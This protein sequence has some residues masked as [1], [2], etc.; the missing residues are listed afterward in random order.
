MNS[1][2]KVWS[3]NDNV[4]YRISDLNS[5]P[6][7]CYLDLLFVLYV[8]YMLYVLMVSSAMIIVSRHHG[9][10]CYIVIY[11]SVI[12]SDSNTSLNFRNYLPTMFKSNK[13]FSSIGMN[14]I[15][16]WIF[17]IN[18][19]IIIISNPSILNPGPITAKSTKNLKTYYQNVQGLIPFGSLRD[20]NPSLNLTKINELQSYIFLE[21]PDIIVL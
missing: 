15:I 7:K 10:S 8:I 14:I 2:G 16:L 18:L 3:I 6:N 9:T 13:K 11:K 21:H 19:K 4:C 20:K 17:M 1:A 12:L 5:K